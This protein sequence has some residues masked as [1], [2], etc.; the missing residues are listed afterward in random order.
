MNELFIV[1]AA[2]WLPASC[3]FVLFESW[4]GRRV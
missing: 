4:R 1:I 3:L 2:L